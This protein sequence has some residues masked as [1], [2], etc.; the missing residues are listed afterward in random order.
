MTVNIPEKFEV[1]NMAD[2]IGYYSV[3]LSDSG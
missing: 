1:T 3:M 2:S